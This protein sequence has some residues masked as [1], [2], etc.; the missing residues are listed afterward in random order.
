MSHLEAAIALAESGKRIFPLVP[1]GKNPAVA[2]GFKA[3]SCDP[4]QVRRWWKYMPT[5]N[6]GMP[7]DEAN[8]L[9]VVDVDSKNGGLEGWK[10]LCVEH[11]EVP[12]YTVTTP[13]GGLH[14]YY[15]W[16][17]WAPRR[18]IG[19]QP[20]IDFMGEGGYVVV[21]PSR[22][23]QGDYRVTDPREIAEAPSWL[24]K[25]ARPE[26]PL[27]PEGIGPVKVPIGHLIPEGRRDNTLYRI[28][29]HYRAQGCSEPEILD[30]LARE[31]GSRCQPPLD[32]SSL[33]R[34]ARSACSRP[35]R[36]KEVSALTTQVRP[37]PS[38]E[39]EVLPY[40][41]L[42]LWEIAANGI[43]ELDWLIPGWLVAKDIGI[44]GGAAFAGKSTTAGALSR[45]L[46]SG[47]EW[48]GI[49]PTRRVPVLYFDEEQG[50]EMAARMF[51]LLGGPVPGLN[52]YSGQGINLSN[53]ESLRRLAASIN[54][55]G[56]PPVV[57]LDSIQQVFGVDDGNSAT[58]VGQVYGNLFRLRDAL[59]AT[60]ILLHHI[61]KPGANANAADR[62]ELHRLRDS[63]AHGTQA[64]TVWFQQKSSDS[65]SDLFQVKRRGAEPTSLRI[66]CDHS[67]S[68][69]SLSAEE[70]AAV[71]TRADQFAEEVATYVRGR[72]ETPR[73]EINEIGRRLGASDSLVDDVMKRLIRDR[74]VYR[75]RKG[76]YAANELPNQPDLGA[77]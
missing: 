10:Y 8:G 33:A 57:I 46:A 74:S 52:V 44:L 58:K 31:N 70:A 37:V 27:A 9:F 26:L 40:V 2:T 61:S 5:A 19:V 23:G 49:K 45:A 67:E 63:S 20:G 64:S 76:F 68:H 22:T 51:L 15:R 4:E 32:Y 71:L 28:A 39:P 11:G 72:R 17:S 55:V 24:L 21:P 48:L 18:R 59:G 62:L 43:P 13:T 53:P 77:F 36:A 29:C 38:P 7:T 16:P 35:A 34:I 73:A 56:P 54:S 30:H 65:S 50:D 3:A 25:I 6:I 66:E 41:S 1:L 42:D 14:L 12:T 75:L 60:F 47:E 69:I